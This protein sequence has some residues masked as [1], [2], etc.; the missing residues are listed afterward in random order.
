M[1]RG[2][3]HNLSW[4]WWTPLLVKHQHHK[5]YQWSHKDILD[6]RDHNTSYKQMYHPPSPPNP[7]VARTGH[8][9]LDQHEGESQQEWPKGQ[10]TNRMQD[11]ESQAHTPWTWM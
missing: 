2:N 7:C 6:R 1:Q 8:K 4:K 5:K 10:L 9:G 11:R 3:L